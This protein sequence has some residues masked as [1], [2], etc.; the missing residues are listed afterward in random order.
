[1][2]RRLLIGPLAVFATVL[3][4]LAGCGSGAVATPLTVSYPA[5]TAG[6]DPVPISLVDQTG[7][8]TAIAAAPAG[9]AAPGV[10]A[11]PGEANTLRVSWEGGPCDDRATLVLNDVGGDRY[12]LAIHNHPPIT[13]GIACDASTV[14]RTV[15]IKLSRQLDPA[16]LTLNIEYP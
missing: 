4:S 14:L 15:D 8:V 9:S 16:Q 7:L 2:R 12:E 10:A 5:S 11:V 3:V 6:A 1:M 13:A